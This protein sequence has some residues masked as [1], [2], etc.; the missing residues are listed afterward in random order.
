MSDTTTAT[1]E[2]HGAC[3]DEGE[4]VQVLALLDTDTSSEL[5]NTWRFGWN[6]RRYVTPVEDE[7]TE[8]DTVYA[9]RDASWYGADEEI[10][11]WVEVP[12]TLWGDYV[13]DS[14]TRANYVALLESYP[15]AFLLAEWGH[16]SHAL[17]L[18]EDGEISS[19]LADE[20]HG[21]VDYPLVCEDT[22]STLELE[23]ELEDWTSWARRDLRHDVESK[24]Y[25][26]LGDVYPDAD[27][28]EITDEEL[29][30]ALQSAR[31]R[32]EVTYET[33]TAVSGYFSGLDAVKDAL[34]EERVK[35]IGDAW[36]AYA[37]SLVNVDGQVALDI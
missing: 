21:L 37:R 28:L 24:I 15:D 20:L 18:R 33:E 32:G 11:A 26:E 29:D 22:H 27:G 7:K 31:E 1:H 9:P 13:G 6:L 35:S 36:E 12:L 14:V 19:A 23:L 10:T 4:T 3:G 5:A 8:G 34:V 30:D 16:G 17:L 25:D 2:L